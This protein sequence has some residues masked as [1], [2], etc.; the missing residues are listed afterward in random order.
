MKQVAT[1]FGNLPWWGSLLNL[2]LSHGIVNW[3]QWALPPNDHTFFQSLI[4]SEGSSKPATCQHVCKTTLWRKGIGWIIKS[5]M[6][7]EKAQ[8]KWALNKI[9]PPQPPHKWG[10]TLPAN[11]WSWYPAR[12]VKCPDGS[13]SVSFQLILTKLAQQ[14]LHSPLNSGDTWAPPIAEKWTGKLSQW[15]PEGHCYVYLCSP[16]T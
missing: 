6:A 2:L 12:N 1:I 10:M 11:W 3:K 4:P 15:G 9:M 13:P 16:S 7:L 5:H 14:W 8:D